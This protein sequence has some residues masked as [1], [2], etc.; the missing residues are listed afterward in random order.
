MEKDKILWVSENTICDIYMLVQDVVF[1]SDWLEG[2]FYVSNCEKEKPEITLFYVFNYFRHDI[3]SFHRQMLD[4]VVEKNQILLKEEFYHCDDFSDERIQRYSRAYQ[5]GTMLGIG[6]IIY[7][8]NGY[9]ATRQESI[10]SSL[11][12]DGKS[13]ASCFTLEPPIPYVKKK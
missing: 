10:L 12:V 4:Q 7:D 6:E 2:V 11:L 1:S 5:A 13:D 9:L 8:S 3:P